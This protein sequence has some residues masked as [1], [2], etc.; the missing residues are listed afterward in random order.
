MLASEVRFLGSFCLFIKPNNSVIYRHLDVYNSLRSFSISELPSTLSSTLPGLSST[1]TTTLT[2]PDRMVIS[3]VEDERINLDRELKVVCEQLIVESVKVVAG[4]MDG[5]VVKVQTVQSIKGDV[6][7]FNGL[8]HVALYIVILSG[9]ELTCFLNLEQVTQ[10]HQGFLQS[11][12]NDFASTIAI[13][14]NY[15]DDE[16]TATVIFS[17]VK[18]H[19]TARPLRPNLTPPCLIYFF[20]SNVADIYNR[21]LGVIKLFDL[22]EIESITDGQQ[23]VFQQLQSLLDNTN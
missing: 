6:K 23:Q 11:L 9:R 21:F 10:I 14:R 5:W 22:D 19:F 2:R 1:I 13:I 4:D 15:L 16:K 20:K 7:M 17:V 12:Q 3:T 18:V 8:S